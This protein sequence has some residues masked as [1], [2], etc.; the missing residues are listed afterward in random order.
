M[1]EYELRLIKPAYSICPDKPRMLMFSPLCAQ[2][3]ELAFD[4]DC[5]DQRNNAL[6]TVSLRSNLSR[7]SPGLRKNKDH[8]NSST[9]ETDNCRI[10]VCH[11][12]T[13]L[14]YV[15]GTFAIQQFGCNSRLPD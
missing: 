10:F 12:P 2:I 1:A 3:Q 8:E 6:V 7:Q 9:F 14:S 5:H 13:F 4:L 15:S 11:P